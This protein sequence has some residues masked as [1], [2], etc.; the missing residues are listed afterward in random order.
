M[1]QD[2][3]SNFYV[4]V[5]AASGSKPRKKMPAG[6]DPRAEESDEEEEEAPLSSEYTEV[7]EEE[8]AIEPDREK[9]RTGKSTGLGAAAKHVVAKRE[10]PLESSE[11]EDYRPKPKP[12]RKSPKRPSL[13]I[14]DQAVAEGRAHASK[15]NSSS[16]PD[17]PRSSKGSMKGGKGKKGSYQRCEHCWG[18]VSTQQNPNSLL[19]HQMWN[20]A[21]VTWQYHNK[22]LSWGE[23]SGK[24]QRKIDR[25]QR[26]SWA[27]LAAE[28]QEGTELRDKK[29]KPKKERRSPTPEARGPKK[30]RHHRRDPDTDS[31]DHEGRHPKVRRQDEHT[32]IL[33]LPK[34]MG[35]K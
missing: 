30:D 1:H 5:A 15:K 10:V 22:G 31:E 13:A 19:Q 21:C 3:S 18:R 7:T 34:P 6:K 11:S 2:M 27:Q 4:C 25:R 26:R 16:S 23:S 17:R 33:K 28:A 12:K 20:H 24:A 8:P 14:R 9:P 35:R 29:K 32:F